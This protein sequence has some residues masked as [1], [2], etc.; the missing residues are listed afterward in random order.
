[1]ERLGILLRRTIAWWIDGFLVA[2]IIVSARWI[3]NAL[4][5]GDSGLL[6]GTAGA[7]YDIVALAL[8]FYLYRVVVEARWATSLGKW[9]LK[10]EVL[11]THP[12]GPSALVRNSWLLL[13]MLSLTGLPFV[14]P[15]ILGIVGLSVALVGQTPFDL[16]AGAQVERRLD[17]AL[18]W[19]QPPA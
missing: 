2:A 3:I 19:E 7:V 15:V 13:P 18:P 16:L 4:T 12:A 14:E 17:P 6:T 10:L 1:M 5:G 11:H 8:V 9:S